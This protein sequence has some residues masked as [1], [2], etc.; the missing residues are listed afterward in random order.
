MNSLMQ[1][2]LC[3]RHIEYLV[4]DLEFKIVEASWGVN[5]FAEESFQLGNDVRQA[6]PELMGLDDIILD[7]F[8][9]QIENFELKG[10]SRISEKFADIYIDIN[11]INIK[12]KGD[13]GILIIIEDSTERMLIEQKL[14]QFAKEYSLALAAL[15]QS[16]NY[17]DKVI[18]SMTDVMF[19]VNRLGTIKTVNKAT[20]SLFEYSELELINININL[21]TP[22]KNFQLIINSINPSLSPESIL[23]KNVEIPCLTK[24]GKILFISFSISEIRGKKHEIQEFLLV[25]RDITER[26]KNEVLIR[27]QAEHDSFAEPEGHRVLKTITNQIRNSLSLEE[28]LTRTVAEVQQFLQ[29]DRVLFYRL[30]DEPDKTVAAEAI[31]QRKIPPL[32]TMLYHRYFSENVKHYQQGEICLISDIEEPDTIKCDPNSLSL[33]REL[34]VKAHLVFPLINNNQFWGLLIVNHYYQSR[35]WQPG[36]IDLLEQLVAQVAIAVHQA[37]LYEQLQEANREL[38]ELARTDSLT[39]I[40]NRGHFNRTLN[41]E[42]KRNAREQTPISLILCDVDYFKL[43]NDT[44][45]HVN[46]DLCLK[47]IAD[48]LRKTAKRPGDL[49]AR[50]GGEEFAMILPNTPT[51][52]AV[53]L[54]NIILQKVRD[55]HIPHR[56]S[57]ISHYVTISI[58]VATVI[59]PNNTLPETI[60]IKAADRALY[61]AKEQGRDRVVSLFPLIVP[62]TN[63]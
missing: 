59:P 15:S 33:L 35:A 46:G 49:A 63:Y 60:L 14:G 52:G 43:Y 30:T 45:G 42:W 37:E 8:Q 41:L 24:T 20:I 10:I 23:V 57:L 58:G 17:L 5:R 13:K 16:K 2:L 32:Q 44:Y 28:I 36:E 54:A 48:I 11:L 38:E 40:G 50:Y 56:T 31:S 29:V 26:K 12:N 1:K 21:I 34:K 62:Q 53:H 18:D 9:D 6:F 7:I 47:K 25:G 61:Q 51:D 55:S 4:I 22:A 3:S 27:Q 19:V 39:L